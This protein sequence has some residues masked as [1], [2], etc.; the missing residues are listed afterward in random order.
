M[1]AVVER[2]VA[3]GVRLSQCGIIC[4]FKAQVTLVRSLVDRRM[5]QLEHLE[6]HQQQ[7]RRQAASALVGNCR[8]MGGDASADGG[9]SLCEEA[10]SLQ[11]QEQQQARLLGKEQHLGAQQQ[12]KKEEEEQEEEEQEAQQ[13][14]QEE[15]QGGIQVATVDSFQGAE[16]DVI[17]FTTAVTR[18][19][20]FAAGDDV[21]AG[22]GTAPCHCW[23]Q[24][25]T[26]FWAVH[27]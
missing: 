17:I 22:H 18:P 5:P 4:L 21:A 3:A 8:D 7:Q 9:S 1:V 27:A 12:S 23:C 6:K 15:Q 10:A 19:G 11:G 13:Q 14:Q 26:C 24:M 20:A 16:C 2:L 25:K